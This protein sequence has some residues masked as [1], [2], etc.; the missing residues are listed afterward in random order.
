MKVSLKLVHQKSIFYADEQVGGKTGRWT[1][2]Q[3]DKQ[4]GG[5]NEEQAEKTT[6]RI[7]RLCSAQKSHHGS[8]VEQ[9][10]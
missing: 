4:A 6:Y 7:T 5:Q 1:N 10:L 2:M 8:R 9:N 3:A